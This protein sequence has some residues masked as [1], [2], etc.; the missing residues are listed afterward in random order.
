MR[1]VVPGG[2]WLSAGLLIAERVRLMREQIEQRGW[3]LKVRPRAGL[4]GRAR[5][6]VNPLTRTVW[7]RPSWT[8]ETARDAAV[9]AHEITHVEQVENGAQG[10]A[11]FLGLWWPRAPFLGR[12]WWTFR[13]IF[14]RAFVEA[15]ESEAEAHEHA[16]G[17]QHSWAPAL[18]ALGGRRIFVRVDGRWRLNLHSF[19]PGDP[20]QIGTYRVLRSR[21][22]R[23]YWKPMEPP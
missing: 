11:R 16:V 9:L 13:V 12:L 20:E 19:T 15:T 5:S 2:Y 21:D 17:I 18:R 4:L 7:M 14:D 1:V 23:R 10:K 3:K 6:W 8:G 22:L